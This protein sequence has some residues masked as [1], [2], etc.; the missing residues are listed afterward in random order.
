VTFVILYFGCLFVLGG[1]GAFFGSLVLALAGTMA[2]YKFVLNKRLVPPANAAVII[3]GCSSGIGLDAALRLVGRGVTVFA[4]VRKV[5]D[6]ESLRAQAK[7]KHGDSAAA[8]LVPVLADLANA[9]Q[10]GNAVQ[11]VAKHLKSN[12]LQLLG[13]VNN[14]GYSETGPVELVTPDK[15]RKQFDV[16]VVGQVAL[17]QAALPLMREGKLSNGQS[18][19][20]VFISSGVGKMTIAGIGVYCASKHALEAIGD[21]F[22]MELRRWRISVS[23][24]EP[25]IIA[26][27]FSQ[28]HDV[29]LEENMKLVASLPAGAEVVAE[30][31][32]AMKKAR[33]LEG[34][35]HKI[36][37]PA[38]VVSDDIEAALFDS[39]PLPRYLSGKDV[40]ML[41]IVMHVPDSVLDFIFGNAY[42]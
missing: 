40:K 15:I 5:A 6:G 12:D 10:I 26:T 7:A 8:K 25:G 23:I 28:T 9:E 34:A 27:G 19:R 4:T 20:L 29:T 18:R 42:R 24:V 13:L 17:T 36:K 37:A 1:V 41:A 16:N 33:E 35:G 39:R 30:Y 31:S 11:T 38:S 2:L 3:T 32:A 21:A 14:A 22:R